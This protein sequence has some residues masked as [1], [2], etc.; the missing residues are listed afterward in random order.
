MKKKLFS[1]SSAESDTL[2]SVFMSS[3]KSMEPKKFSKNS[4]VISTK[5]RN[6]CGSTMNENQS[7]DINT[8][9]NLMFEKS[10]LDEPYL[11]T[12]FSTRLKLS[13]DFELDENDYFEGLYKKKE[14]V[15]IRI[16]LM[17]KYKIENELNH[18]L[19]PFIKDFKLPSQFSGKLKLY[20]SVGP[21][22]LDFNESSL[23]VPKMLIGSSFVTATT[24]TKVFKK[25]SS[26]VFSKLAKVLNKW[27]C[28]E[29]YHPFI[30]NEF[31]FISEICEEIGIKF[32][33]Y[34]LGRRILKKIKNTGEYQFKH[35][36]TISKSKYSS[37]EIFCDVIINFSNHDQKL[38]DEIYETKK[39]WTSDDY[40]TSSP[41]TPKTPN[42]HPFFTKRKE[43]SIVKKQD[44]IQTFSSS[45]ENKF[46][47]DDK[48]G[49]LEIIAKELNFKNHENLD[50]FI[51]NILELDPLFFESFP[52]D[53]FILSEIDKIFWYRYQLN[54]F[55]LTVISK[56]NEKDEDVCC[57]FRNPF[58]NQV[59][60][61]NVFYF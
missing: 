24:S 33:L 3:S 7:L 17:E 20:I 36:R 19:N 51:R 38:N 21:L 39:E 31:H 53:H 54:P 42:H 28:K 45:T 18:F 4:V 23:C 15:K 26:I 58:K 9:E 30:N 14:N 35:Y 49:K 29:Y 61:E 46:I 5:L 56:S 25:K 52:D 12:E 44:K 32:N 6:V 41:Y 59:I 8:L 37:T 34:G 60:K 40:I 1:F 2:D 48:N 43:K 27:N 11:S 47:F 50:L 13:N 22:L 55:D 57:P 16:F 10:Y